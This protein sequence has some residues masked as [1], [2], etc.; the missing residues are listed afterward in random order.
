MVLF[1]IDTKRLTAAV[2]LGYKARITVGGADGD[3]FLPSVNCSFDR[4]AADE[5]YLNVR[6]D[7]AVRI[8]GEEKKTIASDFTEVETPGRRDRC[9]L[10]P[11]GKLDYQI[12]L[13]ERPPNPWI[14]LVIKCSPSLSFYHQPELTPDEIAE[15]CSRD[16]NR[17]NGYDIYC[18]KRNN[19]YRFGMVGYIERAWIEVAGK[20]KWTTQNIAV[21]NGSGPWRI[22]I[23]PDLYAAWPADVVTIGP[24]LGNDTYAS[25]NFNASLLYSMVT[26]SYETAPGDGT[27]TAMYAYDTIDNDIGTPL[28][29]GGFYRG[30]DIEASSL[31][32]T[33][34]ASAYNSATGLITYSIS[35]AIVSG[36]DYHL[37]QQNR[38]GVTYKTRYSA[39][40][41]YTAYNLRPGV[42]SFPE[43]PVIY[44]AYAS[45]R[46]SVWLEYTAAASGIFYPQHYYRRNAQEHL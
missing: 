8:T 25:S 36:A 22:D 32:A 41:G 18:D 39:T 30:T 42:D 1:T 20:R 26:L 35:G 40:G 7:D 13:L 34:V 16:E 46:L 2:A 31:I 28:P 44:A 38:S 3:R 33:A 29:R 10:T 5:F 19:K 17:I 11:A 6:A 27:V 4:N 9:I 21:K 45:R 23:P 12:D 15:G 24:V 14:D 37:A 43:P